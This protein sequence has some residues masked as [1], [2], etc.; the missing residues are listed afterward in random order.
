MAERICLIAEGQLGDLLILTPAIRALRLSFPG[1]FLACLVVQRRSYRGAPPRGALV[2][3]HARGTT[4]DVLRADPAVNC[5]AEIDRQALRALGGTARLAAEIGVVR[6]LRRMRFDTV[7][8]TFPQ[9][10]FFLWAFLAGARRRIGEGGLPLSFLLTTR[11][12]AQRGKGSVLDCYCALAE[13]AGARVSDRSTRV[14]ITDEH[15]ERAE[16]IWRALRPRPRGP[17]IALHP[18]ASGDYR[19]WPP[20]MYAGLIDRL[21]RKGLG[22]VLMGS[23]Y[24]REAVEETARACA[25][26][27]PVAWTDNVL[28]LAALLGKCTLL[29]SNNSG[30]RHAAVA[31]GVPSL[32]VIPRFDDIGWKIYDDEVR[33]GTL[34]SGDPCPACP[35][36]ACR[37]AVPP[38]ERFGSYCMRALGVDAVAARVE[39]VLARLGTRGSRAA[40][41]ASLSPPRKRPGGSGRRSPGASRPKRRGSR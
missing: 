41:A 24:D 21:R 36:G 12:A 22:V 1:A 11:A 7:L 4:A 2:D 23:A 33:A 13:A 16:E 25:H 27:P 29:V 38:G 5:V 17:V 31:A 28:D 3:E 32:A 15:R 39:W 37:N 14:T 40:T 35:P 8:C 18:G 19:I 20:A 6:W 26:V 30:P 10:R 9:E 34:Q